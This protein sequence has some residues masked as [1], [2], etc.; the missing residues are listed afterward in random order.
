MSSQAR[1]RQ[2]PMAALRDLHERVQLS[3]ELLRA[4][5]EK[6]QE[7]ARILRALLQGQPSE[8]GEGD[9]ECAPDE[10]SP[11]PTPSLPLLDCEDGHDP[12]P[13][14]PSRSV[15]ESAQD[16]SESG[17]AIGSLYVFPPE[18]QSHGEGEGA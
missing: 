18:R 12:S 8:R 1:E 16:V 15:S 7:K 2:D 10:E 17:R 9:G 14:P 11:G 4:L 5:L 13:P 6:A 3:I